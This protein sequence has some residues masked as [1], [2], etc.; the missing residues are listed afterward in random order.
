[1]RLTSSAETRP[2]EAARVV[3]PLGQLAR[4]APVRTPA[5]AALS[6][7]VGHPKPGPPD[8]AKLPRVRQGREVA[9]PLRLAVVP[10]AEPLVARTR[11]A[12][13]A[14][15]AGAAPKPATAA[16]PLGASGA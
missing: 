13:L 2:A 14:A 1:M 12:A 11:G 8:A 7:A 4:H 3:A 15:A 5:A 9:V 10:V 6:P 16:T